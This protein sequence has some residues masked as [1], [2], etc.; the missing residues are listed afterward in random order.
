MFNDNTEQPVSTTVQLEGNGV[1]YTLDPWT[2]E[3]TPIATY[4][5]QEDGVSI[6]LDLGAKQSVIIAVAPEGGDFPKVEEDV[7]KRQIKAG[8]RIV[9]ARGDGV[10]SG[11]GDFGIPPK[12]CPADTA[13]P[14][15]E[16]ESGG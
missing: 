1:P 16:A 13:A 9:L 7:Y 14:L 8:R 11:D 4:T 2:G 15:S 6:H 12:A 3:I 10:D 5:E